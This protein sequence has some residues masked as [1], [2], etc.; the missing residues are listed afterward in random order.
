MMH[1]EQL[2]QLHQLKYPPHKSIKVKKTKG[3]NVLCVHCPQYVTIQNVAV[4]KVS[5]LLND[6]LV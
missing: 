5:K 2:V 6:V 1:V 4:W 3:K